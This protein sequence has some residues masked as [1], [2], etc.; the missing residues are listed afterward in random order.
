MHYRHSRFSVAVFF[1]RCV[2]CAEGKARKMKKDDLT[3]LGAK[4][5]AEVSTETG[6][7]YYATVCARGG[8]ANHK[9]ELRLTDGERV[10]HSYSYFVPTQATD[11]YLPFI[12]TGDER[13]LEVLPADGG[14]FY[15]GELSIRFVGNQIDGMPVFRLF[16]H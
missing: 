15:V 11:I 5:C 2:L 9:L 10:L 7:V 13:L 4:R 1:S 14:V 6:A 12:A 16:F 8:D 3:L